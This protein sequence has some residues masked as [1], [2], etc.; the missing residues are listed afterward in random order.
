MA[1]TRY[2]VNREPMDIARVDKPAHIGIRDSL[3]GYGNRC[4]LVWCGGVAIE[5]GLEAFRAAYPAA[6]VFADSNAALAALRE[7]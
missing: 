5:A 7:E 6:R 2:V 1:T 3:L 4:L